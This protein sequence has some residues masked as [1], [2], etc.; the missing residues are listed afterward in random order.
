MQLDNLIRQEMRM[1]KEL[2]QYV[3]DYF[4]KVVHWS[5]HFNRAVH[6]TGVV[7]WWKLFEAATPSGKAYGQL[8]WDF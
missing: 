2:P 1:F 8:K 7:R 3:Q 4:P 6:M 5:A